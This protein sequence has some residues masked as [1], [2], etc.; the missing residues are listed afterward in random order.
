MSDRVPSLLESIPQTA[1]RAFCDEHRQEVV[2]A[3][4][5]VLDSGAFILG[6]Q[7]SAFE[8]E[9]AEKFKFTGAV[10]AASGTDAIVL[11]LRALDVGPGDRVA[12]VSHTAV[13]TVAAIELVGASPILVD[14]EPDTYTM[15]P[16]ALARTLSTVG[17]VKAIIVVHL[18]GQPADVSAIQ[19]VATRFG[20]QVIEDCSQSHGAELN[21]HVTGGMA[22]I[23]TFSFYPTK[24]LGAI[25]DGGMVV[26]KSQELVTRLRR[27]REY[28]WVRRQVSEMPGM[29]SRLDELQASVLRLKLKHLSEGNAR[30]A[31]IAAAYDAGLAAAGL[32]LPAKRRG[33]THVYH[34]YV[35]RHPERDRLQ[36]RLKELGIGT[37]VHYPM[38]VHLQPAYAGRVVVDPAGLRVSEAAARE[39]LSLPMYPELAD[40]MVERVLSAVRRSV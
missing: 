24:N 23:G 22:E 39:V 36:A 30:R 34:Q 3:L 1:P 6:A 2:A 7:V 13:A 33:A 35:V 21:G 25:G 17:S 40:D 14:I 29:N 38:P 31:R 15:D 12:T 27:L 37:N 4:L 28:G 8:E 26:A 19:D 10:G 11:G 18:Y 16:V 5:R 9:F 20:A 32:V